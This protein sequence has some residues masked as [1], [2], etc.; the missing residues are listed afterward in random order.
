GGRDWPGPEVTA[1]G[2]KAAATRISATARLARIIPPHGS[3]DGDPVFGSDC[4]AVVVGPGEAEGAALVHPGGELQV[5]IGGHRRLEI[6]GE[7]RLAVELAA[8]PPDDFSRNEIA[9]LI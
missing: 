9:V 5:G 3:G 6:A 8:E 4:R 1:R 7:H 2:S